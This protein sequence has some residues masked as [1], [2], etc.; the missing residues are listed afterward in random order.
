MAESTT[1][2]LVLGATGGI[3]QAL[4][5]RLAKRGDALL[6]AA[7]DADRLHALAERTGGEPLAIDARDAGGIEAAV[8]RALERFGRLDRAVN[9]VGSIL[10]KPAHLT[11]PAEWEDVLVT[12]LGSAFH[13]VRC[14][15][16]ALRRAGGSVVLMSSAAAG[17][18]LVNHEAIAA[19]KAGIEGLVR[20]AAATYAGHGIRVNAVAPGL[21]R[22]PLSERL[23]RTPASLQASEAMHPL[24]RIG[25]PEEVASAVAWLLD[26]ENAWTTGQVVGVDGGLATLRGRARS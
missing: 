9:L 15:V 24:G 11:R 21:V 1:V 22:T 20:S 7:R 14:V 25:E 23:T 3:G 13:L 16:P 5:E 2:H 26:P 18:G 19:A 4:C 8:A 12:N 6:L 17:V 10:L